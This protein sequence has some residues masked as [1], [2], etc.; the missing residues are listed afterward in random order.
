MIRTLGAEANAA[1]TGEVGEHA[2]PCKPAS[3]LR[4]NWEAIGWR[5]RVRLL[6]RRAKHSQV[7]LAKPARNLE[8]IFPMP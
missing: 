2:K 1:R 5:I 8:S 4:F 3:R 7:S 6:L